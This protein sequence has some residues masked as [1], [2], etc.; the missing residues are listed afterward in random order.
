VHRNILNRLRIFRR[1]NH[2]E[3]HMSAVD[4]ALADLDTATTA[5]ADRIDA[6]IADLGNIDTDTATKIA[7]ETARLRSLAADPT[8]PVPETPQA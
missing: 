1:L 5:V 7:T 4:D 8:N 3:N 2:L 6:L